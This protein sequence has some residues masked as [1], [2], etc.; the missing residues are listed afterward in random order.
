MRLLPMFARLCVV[1]IF[2]IW[3]LPVH[4]EQV[5]PEIPVVKPPQDAPSVVVVLLD[6]VGFGAS[7]TFGGVI[8]TPTLD[9]LANEG[10]RYNHFHTT[11]ICSPTRAALL[12]GR[13]AHVAGVGTVM[14]LANSYP[15]YQGILNPAAATVAEVLRQ[16]GYSTAAFGKWHLTPSWESSPTGP[17]DRWPT[18]AG[19]DK[20]YGFLGGETDQFE[21]TLYEGTTPVHRP[22]GDN[23]HLSED[24]AEQAVGWM[25]LQ[26]SIAPDK[27]FFVYFSP[28]ATHAPHQA[29]PAWIE[30][31]RGAFDTGWDAFRKTVFARQKALGVVPA[32]TILTSRPDLLPAWDSLSADER[33][34]AARMMEVYAGFLAH[35]DAQI[36]K[37][38]QSLKDSGRF[39]NTL[40]IYIVG[41]NG[42][43]GEGGLQGGVNYM[44]A[45][46][47]LPEP[48]ETKLERLDA[49]GSADSYLNYPA[50]W[51]W[52]SNTPFQWMKQIA[53]HLGGTRNPMVVTWPKG[54]RDA[55]GLRS[56]FGHVN[57]IVPTI[58]A[59]AKIAAPDTVNGVLQL[60]MDGNSLV[61]T[62]D[63]ADAPEVHHTQYFEVIGNRAIYHDGWMASAFHGK[64][65]WTVAMG[66]RSRAIEDDRWELYDLTKDFSQ[67]HDLAASHPKKLK[68]MQAR[69]NQEAARVGILPLRDASEERTPM[70][71]LNAGRTLFTYYAGAVGIPESQAPPMMNRSWVLQATLTVEDIKPSGVVATVG[72]T[73]AGWSLYLDSDSR[74]IFEYRVFEVASVKIPANQILTDG[75]HQLRVVFNYDG[76]GYAKGG[77]LRLLVNGKEQGVANVPATPPAFFSID[78]TFDIGVDTGSPAGHYP[79][80]SAIG[81][82]LTGGVLEQVDVELR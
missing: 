21:P 60:A 76:P 5:P 68:K 54:I 24:L 7:S 49:Y 25:R 28:G 46:Q 59:A 74:P 73:T 64:M 27:P 65:P 23:Y 6:D 20:F 2:I 71:R 4:A 8:A 14:N 17:F 42:G 70:P 41:D 19:F 40:F 39:D 81:Y 11:A 44:G 12:T 29:P 50:A 53:S 75:S 58:L 79:A 34:V 72:G 10:L 55:G 51:A 13:D 78:E 63:S 69:F 31:Y 35:T 80:G 26:Q 32:N 67:A 56:Q 82:P 66:S 43:S 22:V 62:F 18:G 48:I 15:G 9:A 16:N 38:V 45:L 77:T 52:A 61:S 47:G 1:V 33:K 3:L 57:D 37:L 36:G 30:K